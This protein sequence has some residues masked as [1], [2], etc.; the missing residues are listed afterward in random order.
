MDINVILLQIV[1]PLGIFIV[2]GILLRIFVIPFLVKLSHKTT[3][4]GD[5]VIIHV[6][7]VYI[8]WWSVLGGLVYISPQMGL[9]SHHILW[10][11]DGLLA[12]FILSITLAASKKVVA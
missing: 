7:Q 10:V 9:K 3:W 8:M 12:F 4:E 1:L 5:D 6:L 2:F 11:K